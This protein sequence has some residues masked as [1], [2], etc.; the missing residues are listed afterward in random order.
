MFFRIVEWRDRRCFLDWLPAIEWGLHRRSAIC[1]LSRYS[2]VYGNSW[3]ELSQSPE[4]GISSCCF[5]LLAWWLSRPLWRFKI[6]DSCQNWKTMSTPAWK[7]I[8]WCSKSVSQ[9]SNLII[10]SRKINAQM[11]T[12][13][14]Q[15]SWNVFILPVKQFPF[16]TKIYKQ[17]YR[18]SSFFILPKFEHS[19]NRKIENNFPTPIRQ[20]QN[21]RFNRTNSESPYSP[22][23]FQQTPR[24]ICE[25]GSIPCEHFQNSSISPNGTN[26]F[27][28][29]RNSAPRINPGPR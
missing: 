29:W 11:S 17:L 1:N 27:K 10:Y 9:F 23:T 21:I 16:A 5:T 15:F 18:T 4:R 24:S 3:Y 28:F 22:K 13:L 2:T 8:L 19:I 14:S 12:V 25:P 26:G 20:T 7:W 6:R